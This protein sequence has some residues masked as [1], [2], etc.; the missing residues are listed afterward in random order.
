VRDSIRHEGLYTTKFTEASIFATD[1]PA[2]DY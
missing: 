1:M 2:N